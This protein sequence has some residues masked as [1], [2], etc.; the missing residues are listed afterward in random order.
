[1]SN[2]EPHIIRPT[3]LP[4]ANIVVAAMS[5]LLSAICIALRL[6]MRLSEGAFGWDGAAIGF[7]A[8]SILPQ[9]PSLSRD[10][11]SKVSSSSHVVLIFVTTL[12]GSLSSQSSQDKQLLQFAETSWVSPKGTPHS[13]PGHRCKAQRCI[14]RF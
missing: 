1:M 14:L 10:T 7:D 2:F 13:T 12:T 5:L 8:V 6:Y 3:V 9:V 11:P 4:L